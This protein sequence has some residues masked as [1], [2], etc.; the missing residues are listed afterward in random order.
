MEG[1][2]FKDTE[3]SPGG[4]LVT[5]LS[6]VIPS[7][8]E[9]D[10]V[11]PL[12]RRLDSVLNGVTW[13]AIYVDDDSPDGTAK[14]IRDIART[15]ARV[16]CILRIGRRGLSSAVI[17]G[18]LSSSSPVVAVMDA[19]L[20]HDETLLPK[21][22]E[23]I[24]SGEADVVI[25]SRY[26]T[27]GSVRN[28]NKTRLWISRFASR[29]SRLVVRAE[30]SDP[31]SGFFMIKRSAFDLAVRQ[32]S[33]QGFK[34]LVD[35][36]ASTSRPFRV[37]EVPYEFRDR[38]HGES[39]LD[40]LVAWEY[41]A[42]L[43]DKTAG[44]F[45]PVRFLQFALIGGL[46]VLVH[47]S[48]LWLAFAMAELRFAVAQTLATVVAMSSNF[49]LNNVLTYRDRRLRGMSLVWGMLTF[50][51]ICSLGVAANVGV[52]ALI[53]ERNYRWWLAG[54]AG[55]AVGAVWNYGMSSIL[56]WRVK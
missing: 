25:G 21:M 45:V 54:L 38:I 46:G 12:I 47:F 34:I 7:F 41:V 22:L 36:F 31:M 42:L 40:S 50:Y 32:L 27:G 39:K 18:V 17:E 35:L 28:W 1:P 30:L 6:V 11:A 29:L 23:I 16:R 13:E 15:N 3:A 24:R 53:F 43:L 26:M 48:I 49:W 52:A 8:N 10:N 9:R 14:V 20:Q 5:E 56:T 2:P 51:A 33:A 4:S 37:V 19:D 55:A 44:R